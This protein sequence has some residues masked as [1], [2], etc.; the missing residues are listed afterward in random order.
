[1]SF[2]IRKLKF[3]QYEFGNY[4]NRYSSFAYR[5]DSTFDLC[6]EFV[7][8]YKLVTQALESLPDDYEN[9]FV[10][11]AIEDRLSI[12]VNRMREILA[13][14]TKEENKYNRR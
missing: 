1:M 2:K 13:A 11:N 14:I 3:L 5:L 4:Y 8:D 12:Y 10:E 7:V 6:C 9:V